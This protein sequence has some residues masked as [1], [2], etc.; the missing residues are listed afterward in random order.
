MKDFKNLKKNQK[1]IFAVVIAIGIVLFWRGIWGL[2][3]LFILPSN[4][5]LS[6]IVSVAA[7]ITILLSSH[8]MIKG[9]I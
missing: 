1:R 5:L 3:D 4:E 8:Y 9:L 2:A 6:Y 7:A